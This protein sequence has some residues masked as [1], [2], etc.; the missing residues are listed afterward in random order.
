MYFS[1]E[2]VHNREKRKKGI[3]LILRRE[4]EQNDFHLRSFVYSA[5]KQ[6]QRKNLR[7]GNEVDYF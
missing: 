2:C 1:N 4:K 3:F 7:K 6:Q 5:M